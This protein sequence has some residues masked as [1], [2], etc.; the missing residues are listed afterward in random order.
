MAALWAVSVGCHPV[1]LLGMGC[2]D[3]GRAHHQMHTMRRALEELVIMNYRRRGGDFP[4]IWPWRPQ[5]FAAN[6]QSDHIDKADGAAT[7][8]ALR[9]FYQ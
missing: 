7:I 6:M 1:V 3:D 4:T 2:H 8:A 5:D 9:E